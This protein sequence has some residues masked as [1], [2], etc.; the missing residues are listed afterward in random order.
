MSYSIWV[1]FLSYTIFTAF[2]PG[3]NNILALNETS[4]FGLKN[5]WKLLIGIYTGFTSVMI[6]CGLF[7]N[8]LLIYIEDITPILK[9]VGAL[10]IIWLAYHIA[11][12]AK[13][14]FTEELKSGNFK[15][16]FFLQ[17]LNVKIILWGLTAFSSFILPNYDHGAS[18]LIIFIILLSLIGNGATHIWAILGE[19]LKSY[20]I[21]YWRTV[22]NVMALI[23]LYSAISLLLS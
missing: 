23:L 3:P 17:F 5:S 13:P 16:G 12:S 4:K 8:I 14:D 1:S 10:Y 6:I 18:V 9:Y 15:K 7:S 22:N 11:K 2:S 19:L 20:L 21:K